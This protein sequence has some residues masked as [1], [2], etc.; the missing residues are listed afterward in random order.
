MKKIIIPCLFILAVIAGAG[1]A[2]KTLGVKEYTSVD[3]LATV[4][5]SYFPVVQGEVKAVAEDRL[6][7]SLGTKDG[8]QKGVVLTVWRDGGEILHPVTKAVIGR[9][10]NEVGSL[11]IAEVGETASIG[12]MKKQLM[13]PKEGDRARITPKKIALALLPLRSDQPGIITE[14]AARLKEHGRFTVLDGDKSAAFLSEKKQRDASLIKEMGSTFTL[15]VVLT[16]EI[17]PSEGKYLVTTGIFYA[18][19]RPLDTIVAMLDLR[20]KRTALGEVEPFFAPTPAVKSDG[21][22]LSFDAQLFAAADLEGT[23]TLQYVLSDGARIRI[24][25]QG[26]AGWKEEWVEKIAYSSSEMQHINLDVADINGNGA[27]EI[28]VTGMLKGAVVSSVIE[29]KD[30]VYQRIADIPG[31]LRVLTSSRKGPMLIG[32]KYDP[33]TFFAGQPKQYAWLD[34]KYGPGADYPIPK[35]VDFYGFAHIETDDAGSLLVALN[36]KE[37]LLVYKNGAAIWKSEETYPAVEKIVMKPLTGIDATLSSPSIGFDGTEIDK[38]RKVKISGR[39]ITRDLN[40]DGRD[41]VMVPKHS[42]GIFMNDF[43]KAD[44]ICMDWTGARLEIIR[45]IADIPGVVLSYQIVPQQGAAA[46]VL[47]LVMKHG[48]LFK[49]DRVRVMN[50][51]LR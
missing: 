11:E 32:D 49:A 7:V 34:G 23:G 40:G 12:V 22:E 27:P 20:T 5:T 8:I 42:G 48:G 13:A 15:D 33:V 46:H 28:F 30:G 14:L 3:E 19:A 26:T 31:F 36:D 18:D 35:N 6:T 37:Q 2:E 50:F 47:A 45:T 29:F 44:F 25:K 38:T 43:D 10:E 39:V 4:I 21:M 1:A 41:E 9:L 51:A 24:F 17:L 16:I